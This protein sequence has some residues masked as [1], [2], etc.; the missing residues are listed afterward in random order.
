[1]VLKKYDNPLTSGRWSTKD[2]K[3]AQILALVGVAKKLMDDYK[4]SYKYNRGFNRE[5]TKG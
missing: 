5:S 4:K 3:D 2:S 1:M